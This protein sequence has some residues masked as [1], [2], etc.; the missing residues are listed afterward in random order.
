MTRHDTRKALD[1][2]VDATRSAGRPTAAF[3]GFLLVKA[4]LGIRSATA[5]ALRPLGLSPQEFG[6]LNQ[7]IV[8]PAL[9]QARLGM[10]LDI[11]RTTIVSMLDRLSDAGLIER[12][13][14]PD[15]RRVYR[16]HGTRKG[17]ALHGK[18]TSVVLEVE[19]KFL[20]RLDGARVAA[21]V[22]ALT[23]LVGDPDAAE[24]PAR[25]TDPLRRDG[26]RRGA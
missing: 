21:F 8:E 20:Q 9:S 19:S 12:S 25:T 1:D 16:I 22:G 2:Q 24:P 5:S 11:D 14:D 26:R 6:L 15:D 3:A 7:V 23:R 4:A 13:P 18:A 10:L 17:A